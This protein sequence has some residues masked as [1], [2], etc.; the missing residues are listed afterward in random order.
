MQR[1]CNFHIVFFDDHKDLC[2]PRGVSPSSRL[3][4]LLTRA[5]IQ[6]HFSANLSKL[7]PS[8]EIHSFASVRAQ[9]FREYLKTTGVYFVMC[10]DGANPNPLLTDTSSLGANDEEHSEINARETSRKIAYR[11][12]ICWLIN[13][14]YNVALINGLEWADTK[15]RLPCASA[16][17]TSSLTNS[18]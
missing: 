1:K 5:A 3:K 10:H 16:M 11:T 12:M 4:Y 15:V 17:R 9:A 6:R 18:T 13:E 8:L 14:S 7:H 2:V